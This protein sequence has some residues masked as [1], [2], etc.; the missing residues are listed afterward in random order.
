MMLIVLAAIGKINF[1][2]IMCPMPL[3][4]NLAA[5]V[6]IHLLVQC[7]A[8]C[9]QTLFP[10]CLAAHNMRAIVRHCWFQA[11]LPHRP[12]GMSVLNQKQARAGHG[13]KNKWGW[14]GHNLHH[15]LI[16]IA[17]DGA[18]VAERSGM[19]YLRCQYRCAWKIDGV[20]EDGGGRIYRGKGKS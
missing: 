18:T 7:I 13:Q 14:F 9:A 15:K 20:A 19:I 6:V 17:A 16:A 2:K 8:A 12:F 5:L 3:N 1:K 4:W 11:A 10:A